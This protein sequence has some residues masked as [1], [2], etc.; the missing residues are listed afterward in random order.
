M[1]QRGGLAEKKVLSHLMNPILSRLSKYVTF[2]ALLFF[3]SVSNS[4]A[5]GSD[6]LRSD[7]KRALH[8][9]DYKKAE[10][11]YRSLISENPKDIEARLGLSFSLLKQ[12]TFPEAYDHAALA[13]KQNPN[14]ARAHALIGSVLLKV[15][16]FTVSIQEFRQ[17][18]NLD[19]NEALAI[20]GLAMIDY[21]ENRPRDSMRGLQRASSL[22]PS[23]PDYVYEL[24]RAASLA[25]KYKQAADAFERFLA[26]APRTD[27]DRRARI[28]GLVNFLRFLSTQEKLHQSSGCDQCVVEFQMLNERPLVSVHLNHA[29]STFHFIVDTG[30]QMS[31]I[32]QDT[33]QRLNIQPITRG[34]FSEA[35]GGDGRFEIVYGFLSSLQVGDLRV[36][37]V[38]VYIR[39]FFGSDS[40][41]VD[42]YLGLKEIKSLLFSIDYSNKTLTFVRKKE[43]KRSRSKSITLN[44]I[45]VPLRT[46]SSGFLSGEATIPGLNA[47]LNFIIDTGASVCVASEELAKRQEMVPFAQKDRTKI[48]GAAGVAEN[49]RIL[50]F[51]S[52]LLGSFSIDKLISVVLDLRQISE[53]AGFGQDGI[54]GGNFLRHFRL[55]F[56]LEDHT[57]RLE[58]VTP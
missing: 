19:Q 52:I 53:T 14:S 9:G 51:P 39:Q 17:A 42:G 29:K 3:F 22:D 4:T 40:A 15:G 2:A 26:I 50:V 13:L 33:A 54:L 7:A 28:V 57:L 25:E 37:R 35:V 12:R 18:L 44:S 41:R 1:L 21:F 58:S 46:T 5:L 56:D 43:S 23:E 55:T 34:G 11:C 10:A 27:T 36:D 38:P 30:S 45:E 24:A 31:V 16:N 8:E 20:A 32:S 49:V 6:T 47:P 48:Y